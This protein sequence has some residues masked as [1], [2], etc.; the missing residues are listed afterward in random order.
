MEQT[1]SLPGRSPE[2]PSVSPLTGE[3]SKGVTSSPEVTP[4]SSAEHQERSAVVPAAEQ[5]SESFSPPISQPIPAPIGLSLD[6]DGPI[7][8]ISSPTVASD[9]DLI[10]KEWV[11]RA[12]KVLVETKD[13]PYRREQEVSRLQADYLLK[14]YGRELGAL[15]D[16]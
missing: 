15:R 9:D 11:E 4:G 14:R 16:N 6:D 13:D 7:P 2:L 8:I 1:P 12:K 5:V 10:E 3:E